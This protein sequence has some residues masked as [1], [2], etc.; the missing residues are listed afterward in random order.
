MSF[1]R[2]KSNRHA[3]D[4]AWREWLSRNDG[5]LKATGVPSSVTLSESHWHDFLQNG[6]LHWHPESNSGFAFT[7]LSAEQM[8]GL[9]AL[10]AASPEY[11][12]APLAGWLRVR[13]DHNPSGQRPPA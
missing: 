12:T 13:L 11:A 2:P 9:L 10:L 1:R 5:R 7:R 8:R 4:R 3:E 6:H